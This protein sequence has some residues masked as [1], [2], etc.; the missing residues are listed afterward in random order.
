M[1]RQIE[2]GENINISDG[3]L[4]QS[5]FNKVQENIEPS[6]LAPQIDRDSSES[7]PTQVAQLRRTILLRSAAIQRNETLTRTSLP[8]RVR[9]PNFMSSVVSNQSLAIKITGPCALFRKKQCNKSC[10]ASCVWKVK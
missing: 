3:S 6:P 1:R 10:V 4:S 5:Y 2:N 7:G 8:A 9:F